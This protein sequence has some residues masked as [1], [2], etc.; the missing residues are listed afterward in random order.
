MLFPHHSYDSNSRML[1]GRKGPAVKVI[2]CDGENITYKRSFGQHP[3]TT[4]ISV[5][6]VRKCE[7]QRYQI[8]ALPSKISA[9]TDPIEKRRLKEKLAA[10]DP[11]DTAI[12]RDFPIKHRII[13]LDDEAKKSQC[14]YQTAIWF[15]VA[16]M[17]LAIATVVIV[18][19]LLI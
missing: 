12:T 9:T 1:K 17:I 19:C 18:T 10:L 7:K 16:T 13:N 2:A 15:I 8:H 6:Q 3:R 5:Q 11:D 4:T 14:D